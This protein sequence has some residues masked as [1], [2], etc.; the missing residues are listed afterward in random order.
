MDPK[1]IISAH[2]HPDA[3]A[4]TPLDPYGFSGSQ[5]EIY[6]SISHRHRHGAICNNRI[7]SLS[8]MHCVFVYL[9]NL[10]A[11]ICLSLFEIIWITWA[12]MH[13]DWSIYAI[14]FMMYYHITW[15]YLDPYV[16]ISLNTY[17]CMFLF[18]YLCS[19]VKY[20]Q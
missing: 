17:V 3:I 19:H 2:V 4:R 13:S 10:F 5:M 16:S 1:W 6:V 11:L 12:Y 20:M 15:N 18:G 14:S 9:S 7:W 8:Y